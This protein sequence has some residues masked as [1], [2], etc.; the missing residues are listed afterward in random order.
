MKEV[1]ME[2][3]GRRTHWLIWKKNNNNNNQ[4]NKKMKKNNNNKLIM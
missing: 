2:R 3:R 1:G 4:I